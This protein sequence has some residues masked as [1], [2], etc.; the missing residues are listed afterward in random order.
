MICCAVCCK[1]PEEIEEYITGAEDYYD[2][3]ITPEEYVI[4]EEGTYNRESGKF[5]CTRCYI[6]I[7]MPNGKAP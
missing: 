4:R 3:S 2:G 5:Y 1:T 7:G 6:M